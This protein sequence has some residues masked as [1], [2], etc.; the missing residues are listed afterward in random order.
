MASG[1][2]LFA[3][4]FLQAPDFQAEGLKALDARK[5]PEAA[6]L[7]AKAI[8]ADAKDYAA[9][10]HLALAFSFLNRDPEAAA[11]YRKALELKPALYEAESNL[12]IL[13]LRGNSAAE[14]ATHLAAA[15]EAK[16]R[17]FRPRYYLA[18]ALLAAGDALKAEEHFKAAAELDPR[19]AAAELG[20]GRAQARQQRLSEGAIHFQKAYALDG[21]FKDALLEL[22]SLYEKSKQPAEAA[23]VYRQFPENPAA[24]ERLGELLIESK[25][26]D[27]AISILEPAV[28]RSGTPASRLALATAYRL[29]N[30]V[31]KAIPQLEAVIAAEPTNFAIRM[32]LGRVLR[33]EKKYAAAAQEFFGAA[34]RKPDSLE[35]W[36]ELAG[37]LILLEDHARALAALDKVKALGGE[38]AANHYFRA[39]TLDKL[40]QFKPAL[41]SYQAFLAVSTSRPDEEFKARQRVRILTRELSKR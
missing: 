28:A 22:A 15:V 12:G 39:I 20:L 1:I 26:F 35:A 32:M 33:D 9:H 31:E 2:A 34:Q 11:E 38:T 18:E 16:P 30:R 10:F 24:Q 14:G 37:M 27:E 25:Q 40:K 4:L 23:A 7:F 21:A 5:Y 3:L 41:E 6:E 17:E 8:E 13:L 29:S 19:S 36:N